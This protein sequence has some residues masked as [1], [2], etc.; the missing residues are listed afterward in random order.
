[1]FSGKKNSA[2]WTHAWNS[3]WNFN[4]RRTCMNSRSKRFTR[5]ATPSKPPSRR[6]PDFFCFFFF[7][8]SFSRAE[9]MMYDCCMYKFLMA[10]VLFYESFFGHVIGWNA[11]FGIR[12][13]KA[14]LFTFQENDLED[15]RKT[16]EKQTKEKHFF[17]GNTAGIFHS[18]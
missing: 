4:S 16:M 5:D 12:R 10:L 8:V 18:M 7:F 1:M 9:K 6:Q 13:S 17:G 15:L 11:S 14:V 2:R 3:C